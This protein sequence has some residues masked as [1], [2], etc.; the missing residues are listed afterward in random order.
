VSGA[1]GA[2]V[3]DFNRGGTPL[4]EIV[5][6]PD[7]RSA[8]DAREFLQLLRRTLKQTGVS[9]VNLEAGSLRCDADRS[10]RD[11]GTPEPV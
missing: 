4:V 6:E 7:V 3:V 10:V 2:S 11:A 9:D 5:T 8:A 1:A